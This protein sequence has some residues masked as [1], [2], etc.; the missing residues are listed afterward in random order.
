MIGLQIPQEEVH[1][2]QD[3]TLIGASLT[4]LRYGSM[5]TMIPYTASNRSLNPSPSN[6]VQGGPSTSNS[7]SPYMTRPETLSPPLLIP[8]NSQKATTTISTSTARLQSNTHASSEILVSAA[9]GLIDPLNTLQQQSRSRSSISVNNNASRERVNVNENNGR[10][11]GGDEATSSDGS[12]DS[13]R[14]VLVDVDYGRGFREYLND[15]SFVSNK[16]AFLAYLSHE[17]R[18]PLHAVLGLTERALEDTNAYL[19]VIT[20]EIE[21]GGEEF[22]SVPL[23]QSPLIQSLWEKL[24]SLQ[25]YGQYMNGMVNDVLEMSRLDAGRVNLERIPVN[26]RSLIASS[27]DSFRSQ[28]VLRGLELNLEIDQRFPGLVVT[29]PHRVMQLVN[30]LMTNA[31]RITKTGGFVKVFVGVMKGLDLLVSG[32]GG[33]GAEERDDEGNVLQG[34][35]EDEALQEGYRS[36]VMREVINDEVNRRRRDAVFQWETLP[37]D[38]VVATVMPALFP[39]PGCTQSTGGYLPCVCARNVQCLVHPGNGNTAT[40]ESS[41]G[42]GSTST[43]SNTCTCESV[44]FM[45]VVVKDSGVGMSAETLSKLLTP[46]SQTHGRGGGGSSGFAGGIGGN[47]GGDDAQRRGSGLGL[48]ITLSVLRLMGGSFRIESRVGVG[49]TVTFRVP[50]K[51]VMAGGR[52]VGAAE[53][54]VSEATLVGGGCGGSLNG[55]VAWEKVDN[56]IVNGTVNGSDGIGKVTSAAEPAAVKAKLADITHGVRFFGRRPELRS[57][58][59]KRVH[60]AES[61]AS[62]TPSSASSSGSSSISSTFSSRQRRRNQPVLLADDDPLNRRILSRMLKSL[63]PADAIIHE[64]ADGVEAEELY[65]KLLANQTST[66]SVNDTTTE[67]QAQDPTISDVENNTQTNPVPTSY[68]IVFMDLHMP[69][70]NGLEAARKLREAGCVAPIVAATAS[71]RELMEADALANGIDAVMGKPFTKDAVNYLMTLF[72]VVDDG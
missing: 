69:R 19:D 8:S 51:K 32:G 4:L 65:A 27:I 47:V 53:S 14:T 60:D 63:L 11:N 28:T 50:L 6:S 10:G 34:N 25:G 23:K 30:N 29:D 42:E 33:R 39:C 16:T 7:I 21:N 54:F 43:S 45:Q 48:P 12:M 1:M 46:Y 41:N 44:C 68:A 55:L 66:T 56:G 37:G 52:G 24:K 40:V 9:S 49:T 22:S 38:G 35:D 58:K 17:L 72:D 2:F 3:V 20:R 70:M 31:M 15:R 64:A 62:S 71:E 36:N 61:V 5:N 13:S 18:N 67:T 59:S 26:L 57:R